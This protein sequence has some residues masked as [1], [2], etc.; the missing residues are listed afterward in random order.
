MTR[1]DRSRA[2]AYLSLAA[3]TAVVL[4][5]LRQNARP[6]AER[7]DG[8]PLSYF[9][10]FSARRSSTGTVVHLVGRDAE[11]RESVLHHRHAGT[12]G[13][14]Q[15][16]RQIRRRVRDGGAQLL[17][18]AVAASVAASTS[19]AERALSEVAVV[20]SVCDYDRFFA[21]DTTPLRRRTH[22]T[23]PVPTRA[24]AR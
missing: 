24:G 12:G 8:F 9:P 22:A 15:V 13:L 20:T 2:T 23:A 11:G 21:G 19:A 16:R 4:L 14:N 1:A 10:M 18:E 17:A 6:A 5:P 3:L 7:R